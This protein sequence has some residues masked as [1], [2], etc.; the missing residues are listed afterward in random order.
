MSAAAPCASPRTARY[1]RRQP[2]R[3]L[4]YRTVQGHLATW[5]E[6]TRDSASGTSVPAYVE[7]EFRR[8]LEC[9][10]LAHG[11]ARARCGQCGHDFLI[12]YSCK[13]R[14]VCPACN[15]RRMVETAAHLTDHVMPRLPVRQWVLSV[16]KRLRYY[17]HSDPAVQTLAL[18][19]FLSAVEQGLRR[20]SPGAGVAWR[21][22]AVA[23]IHGFGALLNPHV[24]FHCVVIEGVFEADGAGGARFHE[25][26]GVGP[27]TVA[28]IQ[29]KVRRRLLRA[30]AR[31]GLLERQDAQAMGAWDHAGGFSLDAS[32]R[33]EA[34]DREGL[35]RLLRYCAR[36]AFALERL[37]EVDPEHLVYESVKPGPSGSVTLMLTPLELL[38]RLAA[39]IPPPRRHRHRYFGVLAPNAPLRAAVTALAGQQAEAPAAQTP[40]A[41][42]GAAPSAPASA[43]AQ[44]PQAAEEPIHRR[45]ARYAWALLL[46]RI[47]EFFPLLCPK[48]GG[49]IRIIAFINEAI[50]VREIL[51]YLGEPTSPPP[52]APARG[53]P[54]WEMTDAGQ[55]ELD[56]QA[57][58]A[59]DYEFDQRIAW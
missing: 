39:L 8:Y 27:E 25:A 15:A 52:M 46:A 9:G 21:I 26:R 48:C 29:A 19:I 11:F 14:G 28:E 1:R 18:H 32:V 22:G 53:P 40:A 54:L 10:I 23:F 7:R 42:A 31:R 37:R 33:I 5:L 51:A 38:D 58:P 50:A 16:P 13:G 41:A 17:L 56:P 20:C 57:Q 43:S 6:L 45:A 24:H 55:G 35:E 59:P 49:E 44:T 47:Y 2:E 12:A 30:A 3:T 34:Q 36:P 4:L